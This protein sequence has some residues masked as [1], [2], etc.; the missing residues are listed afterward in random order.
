MYLNTPYKNYTQVRD[1]IGKKELVV[2]IAKNRS[3][4]LCSLIENGK[5]GI[6]AGFL[7]QLLL[8]MACIAVYGAAVKSWLALPALLLYGLLPFLLPL[9]GFVSAA[10]TLVGLMGLVRGWNVLIV[11][12]LLPGVFYSGGKSAW[13]FFIQLG[14]I[15]DIMADRSQFEKFW[16]ER[17]F[18]LQDKEGIYQYEK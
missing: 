4:E 11:A 14:L 8:P 12:L 10:M 2:R 6:A 1:A 9:N 15:K 17:L 5:V 3:S 13:W 16:K 7:L 18:A